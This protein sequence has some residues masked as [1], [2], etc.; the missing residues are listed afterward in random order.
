MAAFQG[1]AA[2]PN[3]SGAAQNMAQAVQ[4]EEQRKARQSKQLQEVFKSIG[5]NRRRKEDQAIASAAATT[6]QE[7]AEL[8]RMV[9][10]YSAQ[11]TRINNLMRNAPKNSDYLNNQKEYKPALDKHNEAVKRLVDQQNRLAANNPALQKLLGVSKPVDN[12][13]DAEATGTAKADNNLIRTIVSAGGPADLS[14]GAETTPIPGYTNEP[15]TTYKNRPPG[16]LNSALDVSDRA[17]QDLLSGDEYILQSLWK[18][19]QENQYKDKSQKPSSAA[20]SKQAK[21]RLLQGYITEWNSLDPASKNAEPKRRYLQRRLSEE[22][23]VGK[24]GPENPATGN[25]N[26]SSGSL[27]ENLGL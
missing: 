22:Y 13:G 25:A 17:A 8:D 7:N 18:Q 21:T 19:F 2:G 1:W 26:S 14:G 15:I 20:L 6:T 12:A 3:F 9:Q 23:T 4:V 16:L 27:F 10:L 11:G 24:K 5:D